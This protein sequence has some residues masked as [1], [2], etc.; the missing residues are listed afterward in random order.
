M[1]GIV[2]GSCS[3]DTALGHEATL[4]RPFSEKLSIKSVTPDFD[5]GGQE[6]EHGGRKMTLSVEICVQVFS[7][8]VALA[9]PVQ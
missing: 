6:S 4:K 9:Q 5:T 8:W 3:V 1:G 2:N 7:L